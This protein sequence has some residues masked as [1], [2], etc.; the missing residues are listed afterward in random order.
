M[1]MTNLENT[2]FER[3]PEYTSIV[4]AGGLARRLR[5]QSGGVLGFATGVGGAMVAFGIS[6]SGM[7]MDMEQLVFT[8]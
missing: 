8:F 7:G 5:L 3:P 2:L 1:E 6:C 4:H